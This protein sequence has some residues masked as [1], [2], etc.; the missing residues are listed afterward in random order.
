MSGAVKQ[1]PLVGE[2]KNGLVYLTV[3][4]ALLGTVALALVGIKL[5]G[6]AFNI[7]M[8][9]AAYRKELV[10]GEDR[11]DRAVPHV[12]HELFGDVRKNY[13]SL[14]WA[15]M[16]FNVAKWSYLQFGTIVPYLALGPSIANAEITLGQMNRI[17]NAFGKVEGSLQFLVRSW[18]TIVELIS[19]YKRLHT[20]TQEM[21]A[22]VFEDEADDSDDSSSGK[23]VE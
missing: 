23:E 19:V 7:Q 15:Y 16:Y 1:M 9:E 21:E 17:T 12:A 10:H 6:L 14:F 3:I 4:W 5:P 8:V 20:F 11:E 2:V 18:P 13:F 22:G